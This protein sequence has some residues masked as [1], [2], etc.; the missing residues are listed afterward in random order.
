[1][2][3]TAA[4]LP[5]TTPSQSTASTVTPIQETLRFPEDADNYKQCHNNSIIYLTQINYEKNFY[6]NLGDNQLVASN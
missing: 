2:L 5:A 1:M 4:S 6:L 3:P